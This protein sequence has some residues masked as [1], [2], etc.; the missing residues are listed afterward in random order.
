[1]CAVSAPL[2]CAHRITQR[3]ETDMNWNRVEGSWKQLSGKADEMWCMLIGDEPGVDAARHTQLAGS[4]QVRRGMSEEEAERQ[5]GDFAYRNR[6]WNLS[7][8]RV[9]P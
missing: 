6:D 9:R 2:L 7:R 8:R 4:I 1:M 5:I 3:E